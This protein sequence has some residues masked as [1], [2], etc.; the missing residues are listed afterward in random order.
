MRPADA[1]A[2]VW[3]LLLHGVLGCGAALLPSPAPQ[4]SWAPC[5]SGSCPSA[6]L[7]GPPVTPSSSGHP[8]V[9]APFTAHCLDGSSP[10]LLR[11]SGRHAVM[12]I[13]LPSKSLPHGPPGCSALRTCPCSHP[14]GTRIPTS[15]PAHEPQGFSP[16]LQLP[17]VP[18][19]PGSPA[20][21]SLPWNVCNPAASGS[22]QN[23]VPVGTVSS[24]SIFVVP[25]RSCGRWVV[26]PRSSP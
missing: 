1:V 18:T 5:I 7:P 2:T 22:A 3:G 25:S 4:S 8:P 21:H 23:R 16:V 9:P 10:L 26:A 17:S 24:E 14:P 20:P 15:L 11:I 19:R 6:E 12:L 13:S